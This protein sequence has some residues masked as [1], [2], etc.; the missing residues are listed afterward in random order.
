MLATTG[1]T[2]GV[3]GYSGSSAGTGVFGWVGATSGEN[4]GVYGQS[5]SSGGYGVYGVT[6]VGQAGVWGNAGFGVGVIGSSNAGVGVHG[7]SNT[8][9]GI[10][11][12]SNSSYGVYG[13]TGSSNL[14]G[15]Y[16]E[17]MN[18]IGVEANSYYNNGV[19][20]DYAGSNGIYIAFAGDDGI[21]VAE[22]GAHYGAYI[23][24]VT[25]T[26]VIAKGGSMGAYFADTNGTW[27]DIAYDT[28]AILSPGVKSFIQQDPTDP[29]KS[30]IYASLEGGEAGTYYRGT[31]KLTDGSARITLPEHFSLVTEKEGLTVQIS[32]RED[33]KGLYVAEVTTTYIVVK[34]LQG[35]KSSARFDFLIN[36]VRAGFTDFKVVVDTAQIEQAGNHPAEQTP[37][38]T[39][40][41]NPEE[42]N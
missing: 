16:G 1:T 6:Q 7:G 35:G 40:T 42:P 26:G 27:S 22:G 31:G 25:Y 9:W 11:G 13:W 8:N 34:E 30:I 10:Y 14:G 20:V 24:G 38:Q 37:M 21:E 32:P 33:C 23:P 4:Y 36:G 12:T 3:E 17:S 19:V 18:G 28:Y 2:A 5:N 39:E 41:I 29:T 15:V